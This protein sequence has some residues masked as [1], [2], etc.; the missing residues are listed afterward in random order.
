MLRIP[1]FIALCAALSSC[2]NAVTEPLAGNF[3]GNISAIIGTNCL[4][5]NCHTGPSTNNTEF[6]L[7]T[8]DAMTK[9]SVY[10]NEVI[11][12][13]AVKSHLFGHVNTNANLAPV[14]LPTMPLARNTLSESD[15]IAIFN[16]I[17]QGAKSAD[18]RTPY[19]N[20]TK[21][22]FVVN[23]EEDMV[24]VLDAQTQRL[25][26]IL[27]IGTN[28]K[29]SSIVMMPDLKSF[30]VSMQATGGKIAKYDVASYSK[31]GEFMSNLL[32]SEM[33]LTADGSKGYVADN[34]YYGNKFGVFD[35]V[36]MKVMKTVSSPLIV[37]P[38]NVV[39]A[40]VGNFAYISGFGSDNILRIDTRNDSVMGCIVLGADVQMPVTPTYTPK[41]QPKK[42][43]IS[44]DGNTMFVSCQGTS[45]IVELDLRKD[46][47]VARIPIQYGPWGEAISPDGSELWVVNYLSNQVQIISTSTNNTLAVIDSISQYPR[48]ITFTPDGAYAFVACE[49]SAGG[50]HH[51]VTGGL[52]PSSYVVINCRTRKVLS[53]QELPAVSTSIVTGYKN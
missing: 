45:E 53:I 41:Y 19:D 15:Q 32:P 29:P 35:P 33:A 48:A 38:T 30:L 22:I 4:G 16:W 2:T 3:P 28:D 17:T 47:I 43:F 6:D 51:H 18:G 40:P 36:A 23:Q 21:K 1:I 13:N 10:F 26:R 42:I 11:P 12:F 8:W 39:V 34:S 20:V 46:S 31:L 52:P 14:I 25:I 24:S 50:V 9:G 5:G 37:Q 49:L 44:Q 7:S 27:T